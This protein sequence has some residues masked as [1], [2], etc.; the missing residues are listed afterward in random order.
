MRVERSPP[1]FSDP[2]SVLGAEIRHLRRARQLTLQQL[3]TICGR[4]ISFLSKIERGSARPSLPALQDIAEALDVQIGWFFD[5]SDPVPDEERPYVVRAGRHRRLTYSDMS[6]TDYL[7][8]EDHL[9][10]AGLD[11]SLAMGMSRY[12][13]GGSTGDDMQSHE[14]EEAGLVTAGTI[15]LTLD[16][17]TFALAV[18]DS[19][20]FPSHLP[21]RYENSCEAEAMIVWANT[22]I[23]LRQK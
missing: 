16:G 10:S 22:P 17:E 23:S 4:S 3:S 14:G 20:S 13:P 9:L 19:F 2:L 11:G 12:R 8:M 6:S 5:E 1:N 18:G 15:D 7:G 21:H